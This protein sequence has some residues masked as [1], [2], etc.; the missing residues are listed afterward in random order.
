LRWC[1]FAAD[2]T[3][4]EV[5]ASYNGKGV[6]C[7]NFGSGLRIDNGIVNRVHAN[8]NALY[9]IQTFDSSKSSVISNRTAS[10]N[11]YYG[12]LAESGGQITKNTAMS[13]GNANNMGAGISGVGQISNNTV[14]SNGYY[15][16][17]LLGSNASIFGNTISD[18]VSYGIIGHKC[19][20]Y[21]YG[22]NQLFNNNEDSSFPQPTRQVLCGIQMGP[23]I[24]DGVLCP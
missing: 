15:G 24:C 1:W 14:E 12:I 8:D 23:N 3:I 22:T 2:A 13:N 5:T 21:S 17:F 19:P 16:I 4:E 18:N 10:E 11:Q 7:C 20:A 6:A 9:G